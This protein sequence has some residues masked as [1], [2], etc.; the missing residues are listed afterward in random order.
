M[1]KQAL[2][3]TAEPVAEQKCFALIATWHHSATPLHHFQGLAMALVAY[4]F[5]FA[6]SVHFFWP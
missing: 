5:A 4:F 2:L 3:R 1:E 6:K